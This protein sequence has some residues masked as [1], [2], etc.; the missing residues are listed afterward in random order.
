MSSAALALYPT[1]GLAADLYG[2]AYAAAAGY[3]PNGMVD[4][5]L[6]VAAEA[7]SGDEEADF[8]KMLSQF[9]DKVSEHVAADDP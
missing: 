7:P 9:K 5:L 8:A 4:L 2:A 1:G 3:D 6:R